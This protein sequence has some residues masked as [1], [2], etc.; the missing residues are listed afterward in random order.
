MPTSWRGTNMSLLLQRN[1]T[2]RHAVSISN[3]RDLFCTSFINKSKE[4]FSDLNLKVK[5]PTSK[6]FLAFHCT[7]WLISKFVEL[8]DFL[9]LGLAQ[10]RVV[11]IF[12]LFRN[13]SFSCHNK[14]HRHKD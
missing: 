4:K 9:Q 1:C 2:A 7:C 5:L 8:I 10:F 3:A 12:S 14:C 6:A 11:V 13:S